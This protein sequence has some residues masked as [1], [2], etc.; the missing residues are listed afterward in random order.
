MHN[1]PISLILILHIVSQSLPTFEEILIT[2]LSSMKIASIFKNCNELTY[3]MLPLN[4]IIFYIS[5]G[6]DYWFCLIIS[7]GLLI[8]LYLYV[9][10]SL[11]DASATELTIFKCLVNDRNFFLGSI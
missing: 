11:Q 3:Q 7:I 1:I 4:L 8:A 10:Y 2:R 6:T 9:M 5:K